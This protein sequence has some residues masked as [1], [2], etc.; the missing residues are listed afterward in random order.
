MWIPCS[1]LFPSLT[2]D[3][4]GRVEASDPFPFSDTFDTSIS[5]ELQ[6]SR[7]SVPLA[8][9]QSHRH[10]WSRA[11]SNSSF[12]HPSGRQGSLIRP[13]HR[14]HSSARRLREVAEGRKK[15]QVVER[16]RNT[17]KIQRRIL[18]VTLILLHDWFAW[19]AMKRAETCSV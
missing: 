2:M 5:H 4:G 3:K 17:F 9:W 15:T 12:D 10:R 8:A 19:H 16:G 6:S 1:L 18:K 11:S 14:V 7:R 13:S